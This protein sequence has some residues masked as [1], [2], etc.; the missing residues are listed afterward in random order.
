VLVV[1]D[2]PDA[3]ET[4]QDMLELW[5]HRVA[6]A[7]DGPQGVEQAR[8]LQPD[9]VLIDIGL[10]GF[11]GYE[12][13]RQVR[14]MAQDKRVRLVALTGYGETGARQRAEEAG[15]DAYLVKPVAVEELARVLAGEP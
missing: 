15:F 11:D 2:N 9:V 8:S 7:A 6:T 12:T 10:P 13:A 14:S 5:G 3:R 1:E 4:L